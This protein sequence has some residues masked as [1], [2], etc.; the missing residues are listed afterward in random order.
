MQAQLKSTTAASSRDPQPTLAVDTRVIGKPR[1]FDGEKDWKD[2]SIVMRSYAACCHEQLGTLMRT[3]EL[4][5]Y[6]VDNVHLSPAD[7]QFSTQLF[8]MLVMV[9]RGSALTR[10]VNQGTTEGLLAWR[11]LCQHHEPSSAARHASLPLDLLSFNFDGDTT[12]RLEQCERDVHRYELSSSLLLDDAIKVGIVLWQLPD[13]ALKQHLVLNMD[14]FDTWTNIRTEIE[15]VRRAQQA[16]SHGARPMDVDTLALLRQVP[17]VKG[18]GKTGGGKG[19]DFKAPTTNCPICDK[20]GHW[21]K[22]CWHNPANKGAGSGKGA[23]PKGGKGKDAK[24]KSKANNTKNMCWNCGETGH[25]R[26]ECKKPK[27]VHSIE[28]VVDDQGGSLGHLFLPLSAVSLAGVSSEKGRTMRVGIDS[29]AAVTAV[30][31]CHC[32]GYPLYK[33]TPSTG[34]SYESAA[35]ENIWDRGERRLLCRADGRLRGLRARACK[36]NKPLLSV[37]DM[38]KAGQMVVIDFDSNGSDR[39]HSIHKATG[40]KTNFQLRNR[41]WELDLEVVPQDDQKQ[42][43]KK[44]QDEAAKLQDLRPFEG[45]VRQM[46]LTTWTPNSLHCDLGE[47]RLN[48]RRRSATRTSAR[49]TCRTAP[50][51][52]RAWLD[53]GVLTSTTLC[54]VILVEYLSWRAIAATWSVVKIDGSRPGAVTADVLPCKGIGDPA[55]VPALLRAYVA[56]GHRKFIARSDGEPAIVDLKS[57]AVATARARHNMD[58]I[59]EETP[60]RDSQANGLIESAVRDVK[61]TARTLRFAAQELHGSSIGPNHPVL[62]WLVRFAGDVIT[63]GPRGADGVTPYQRHTGRVYRRALPIFSEVLYLPTGKHDSRIQERWNSGLFVGIVERSNELFIVTR[64]GVKRA[65]AVRRLAAAERAGADLLA[66]IRGTPWQPI[67]SVGLDV[68]PTVIYDPVVSEDALPPGP[69]P[70]QPAPSGRHGYM[71]RHVELQWHGFTEGRFTSRSSAFDLPPGTAMDVRSGYDFIQAVE[72]ERARE[73]RQRERPALLVGSPPNVALSAMQGLVPDSQEWKQKL[74]EGLA[75]FEFVCDLYKDQM[76]DGLFFLHEHSASS[77]SWDLWMVQEIAGMEGVRTVLGDQCPYGLGSVDLCGP[78]LVQKA[79]RWLT[80]SAVIA[81]A[82]GSRCTNRGCPDNA[83]KHRHCQLIENPRTW[84]GKERYPLKLVTAILKGLR[85]ELRAKHVLFSFEAGAHVDEPDAWD[86]HPEWCGHVVDATTGVKL[87]AVL[88]SKARGEE[89]DFL[90]GLGAYSYDTVDRC[91]EETGRRPIPTGWVDVNKGQPDAPQVRSRLVV[92]ET[93]YHTNLDTSGGSSFSQTPPYEALRVLCSCQMTP[94][95]Q[96]EVDYVIIFIDI[97]RAHPYCKMRRKVWVVLPP[98]DPKAAEPGVCGLLERSLY[99]LRDA[100]QSFELLVRETMEALGF[101]TG[102][103][104]GVV[105]FH[106]QRQI[107]AYVYGDNFGARGSRAEVRRFHESL[108]AHMWAKV[109][110]ILGPDPSRGD[111]LEVVCLNRVFQYVRA[112][113]NEP[114]RIEIEADARHVEFLLHQAGLSAGR[115]AP[116][117]TPGAAAKDVDVGKPL[118]AEAATLFRSMT[119]RAQYLS[120]DRPDIRFACREIARFMAEPCELGAKMLKR[121]C[122]YLLGVP[123]LV[124]RMERQEVPTFVDGISDADFAGC[125]KTR[126]STS[127]HAIKTGSHTIRFA[128]ATQS[129]IAQSSGES[130]Y[131]SLVRCASALIGMGNLMRDLGRELPLRL[132]GDATAASGMARRRGAGRVRH[133]EV[134]TLWLQQIIT[135]KKMVL[136][137]RP[138]KENEA[139]LGTKHLAQR[140][141][142]E[143]LARLGFVA[144]GGRSE[145]SLRASIAHL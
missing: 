8:Y 4:S 45:Q 66:N 24:D 81:R 39:S 41:V 132:L 106:E 25:L 83:R 99:G 110:G 64:D 86:I 71:R 40:E 44:V 37:Y 21:K 74:A 92:K 91:I 23:P 10:V 43:S 56:A 103:W 22:D 95:S 20:P 130:E 28:E 136:G 109:E 29:G 33:N 85:E 141:L 27:K 14:R 97:T 143:C 34:R 59:L 107:Q 26:E 134:G 48:L 129:V 119:M 30:P 126:K 102:L 124:Q 35:G 140:E 127:C 36:V 49:A 114:E 137:R 31:D 12:A 125:S 50:G 138:G 144:M 135:E 16:A 104:C 9:C 128:S 72:R 67:P 113:G 6:R 13:G 82:V 7:R 75:H 65:K 58:V 79:T 5:E 80:N 54:Q 89:M 118:G 122:R 15:A 46:S 68:V 90:S 142:W 1:E 78:A 42:Q 47:P 63:R 11:A 96:M 55:C 18:K 133:I 2:W 139:D 116:L 60:E 94:A 57:R 115:S 145:K 112:A 131:Y 117:S 121:L 100:G 73:T 87:D 70:G 52:E 38:C 51:A 17:E 98:E 77:A 61:A 105:F 93:R 76:K 101:K 69:A 3:A 32:K 120:E 111:S 123:R 62:P 53:V 84:R 19:R 88:V 108:S